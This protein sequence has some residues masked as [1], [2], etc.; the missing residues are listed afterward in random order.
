MIVQRQDVERR[1]VQFMTTLQ[2]QGILDDAVVALQKLAPK[3]ASIKR[4][5]DFLVTLKRKCGT[6]GW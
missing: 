3:N 6:S 5:C 1:L 4:G 2:M